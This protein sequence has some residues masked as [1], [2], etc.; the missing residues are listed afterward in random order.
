MR[1]DTPR[2]TMTAN[3]S[4]FNPIRPVVM[5]KGGVAR[6]GLECGIPARAVCRRRSSHS[7]Q[8]GEMG[9]SLKLLANSFPQCG[10]RCMG[11]KIVAVFKK[12]PRTTKNND[13]KKQ[14]PGNRLGL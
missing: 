3:N 14:T 4:S 8:F 6:D 9:E 11:M 7:G 1:G 5:S 13:E 12:W 2:S 10:Q